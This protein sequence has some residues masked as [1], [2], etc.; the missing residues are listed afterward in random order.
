MTKLSELERKIFFRDHSDDEWREI[1]TDVSNALTRA[2]EKE[3]Q[4]FFDSG[5]GEML[6]QVMEYL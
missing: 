6:E 5:A 2:T 4:E 1:Y 3:R